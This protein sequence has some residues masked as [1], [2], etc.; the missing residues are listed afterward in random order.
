[1][2]R[3]LVDCFPDSAPGGFVLTTS[4]I[5]PVLSYLAHFRHH[6]AVGNMGAMEASAVATCARGRGLRAAAA[7][8]LKASETIDRAWPWQQ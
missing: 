1:M 2:S 8:P 4:G 5:A 6:S 7:S 3:S